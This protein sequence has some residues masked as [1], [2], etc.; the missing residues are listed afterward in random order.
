MAPNC[1]KRR[2]FPDPK[3][4]QKNNPTGV[5]NVGF[6]GV[7]NLTF[8]TT[9]KAQKIVWKV[10]WSII[11]V[12]KNITDIL[13]RI[14]EIVRIQGAFNQFLLKWRVVAIHQPGLG[15][16]LGYGGLE[17]TFILPWAV[18]GRVNWRCSLTLTISCSTNHD[19]RRHLDVP[20]SYCSKLLRNGVITGYNWQFTDNWS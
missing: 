14:S 16:L 12:T 3:T 5:M 4:L 9:A 11:Y 20:G 2:G 10:T 1:W 15:I 13:Q 8:T 7:K 19:N 6:T 18:S 17:T